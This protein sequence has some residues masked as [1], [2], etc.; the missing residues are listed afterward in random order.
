MRKEQKVKS[1]FYVLAIFV[2]VFM[3]AVMPVQ[4]APKTKLSAKKVTMAATD[5]KVVILKNAK[6]KVKWTTTN[7]KVVSIKASGKKKQKVK[8]TAK[9]AGV[10]KV[11]AKCGGK[12]YTIKVTVKDVSLNTS[13]IT[14]S[15]DESVDLKL[16][17]VTK[18]VVWQSSNEDIACVDISGDKNEAAEVLAVNEG[19]VTVTATYNKK[20]YNCNITVTD[21]SQSGNGGSSSITGSESGGDDEDDDEDDDTPHTH[22]WKILDNTEPTCTEEGSTQYA[23]FGCGEQK[24]E[25]TEAFGHT[26]SEYFTTD[27]YPSCVKEDSKS[28]HCL[29]CNEPLDSETIEALDHNYDPELEEEIVELS[30]TV[31]GLIYNYCTRC[32]EKKETILE[33]PGHEMAFVETGEVATCER[34]GFDLYAC[35]NEYCDYTESREVPAKGHIEPDEDQWDIT[36]KEGCTTTG[37]KQKVC[38]REGCGKVLLMADIPATGH[39]PYA[40]KTEVVKESV[41]DEE[42]NYFFKQSKRNCLDAESFDITV[43]TEEINEKLKEDNLSDTLDNRQK[44][45]MAI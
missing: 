31:D 42:R 10:A 36:L 41:C 18:D 30:C 32:G 3:F 2:F 17:N 6:S 26:P 15:T 14:I 12:T 37:K 22:V 33:H 29:T 11:K 13:N 4:A 21:D 1:I 16:Y 45:E 7:K 8:I 9:K 23:C 28:H 44:T 5:T 35:Q 38:Q 39:D 27:T 25:I 20:V 43:T 24:F 34:K 40:I 19:V